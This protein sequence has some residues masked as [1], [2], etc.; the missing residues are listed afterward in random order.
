VPVL[1][2]VATLGFVAWMTVGPVLGQGFGI[3]RP[4]LTAWHMYRTWGTGVLEVRMVQHT[5][6]GDVPLDRL[7]A[8][9]H[10]GWRAAGP[11]RLVARKDKLDRQIARVC[12][13]LGPGADLRVHVREG[14][15]HG[16]KP[17]RTGRKN[18]CR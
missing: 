9:G 16:W 15:M 10:D 8:L 13:A 12:E 7:E 17:T 4:W 1:R 18:A 5:P 11:D 6:H 14:V 3:N 2:L